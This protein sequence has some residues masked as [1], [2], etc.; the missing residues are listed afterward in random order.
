MSHTDG[1]NHGLMDLI[2]ESG[3]DVADAVCPHPMTKVSLAEYYRRWGD[4][5]T[6]FGGVPSNLLLDETTSE[7]AFEDYI[8]TLFTAVAPGLRFMLAIADTTPPDANFDR[9]RRIHDLV[10]EKGRCPLKS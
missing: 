10:M 4:R 3:I 9:L 8:S 5:I 6:I 7:A 2:Y 1:E